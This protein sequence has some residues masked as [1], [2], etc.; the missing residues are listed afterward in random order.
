M[1][2][3]EPDITV[4][5]EASDHASALAAIGELSPD[6]VVLDVHLGS[7]PSGLDLLGDIPPTAK[8]PR[9]LIVTVFDND[10]DIDAALALGAAG[11]VLKDAPEDELVNAVR[12]VAAGHQPLDPRVAAR[13][14]ARSQRNPDAPS[15]RELE[16]LAAVADG[17]DNASIARRLFISQATVKSHLASL[18]TKLG[19]ATRTG[20]VAEAR[21]RSHL[22]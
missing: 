8:S 12:A 6:V 21:R 4:I 7:G 3:A 1:L 2:D 16:V 11:Y 13:V 18:F 9:V 15:P 17:L 19:V 10:L 5:G 20:A 14:V 22:R